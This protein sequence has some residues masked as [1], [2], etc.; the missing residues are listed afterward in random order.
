MSLQTQLQQSGAHIDDGVIQ[1]FGDPD[2]ERLRV[3]S[4]GVLAELSHFGVLGFSGDDAQA[5]LQGQLSCDVVGLAE[6]AWVFGSYCSPK[7]RILASFMHWRRGGDYFMLLPKALIPAIQKRLTMYVLRSKVKIVDLTPAH[8]L[9][10][11]AGDGAAGALTALY[12]PLPGEAYA[13]RSDE[14]R[15]ALLVMPGGRYLICVPAV[16][17]LDVWR[18]LATTLRPVG[19]PCWEWLDVQAGIPWIVPATQE[20]YVPQMVNLDRI[21]GVSFSKGCYPGQEIVARTQYR[22]IL[23]RRMFLAHLAAFQ[24]GD[25]L[26]SPGDDV[27]ADDLPGQASGSVVNAQRV[28]GG[29]VDLLA[30]VQIASREGSRVHVASPDGP[31]LEFHPLPYALP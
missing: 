29:G 22:G 5:F 2:G 6:H 25:V 7:G 26:P 8:S 28:A 1:H 24:D 16:A 19:T 15:G 20:F 4:S 30:V 23:K 27:F 21:G 10:G 14:G 18:E 12:G 9:L 31:I 3:Q 17:A 11:A 13:M